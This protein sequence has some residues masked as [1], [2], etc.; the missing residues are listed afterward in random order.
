MPA[1]HLIRTLAVA[2]VLVGLAPG[3]AAGAPANLAAAL[4]RA[5]DAPAGY[6]VSLSRATTLEEAT[7]GNTP[8]FA[9]HKRA[10]WRGGFRREFTKP[11]AAELAST[12]ARYA[13]PTAARKAVTLGIADGR[14]DGAVIV[15]RLP[16]LGT[17][18][19]VLRIRRKIGD[20][21]AESVLIGWSRGALVLS[22]Q[23]LGAPGLNVDALLALA[24]RQ[25]IR[26]S[27]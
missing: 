9:A 14:S 8:A 25:D 15:R 3:L 10:T 22:V 27:A 1:P 24:R 16:G 26:A 5:S 6:R 17:G 12:A 2:A 23:A 20:V 4:L 13:S 19:V 18:G 7:D 11:G 21:T